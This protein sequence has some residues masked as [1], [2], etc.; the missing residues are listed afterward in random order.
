MNQPTLQMKTIPEDATLFA[1]FELG[2]DKWR[3]AF[4]NA[5]GEQKHA[6]IPAKDTELL[7]VARMRNYFGLPADALLV[8]CYEC[9]C[10]ICRRWWRSRA[11]E[12]TPSSP[13]RWTCSGPSRWIPVSAR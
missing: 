13:F 3:I 9:S 2:A 1:S 4:G 6:V 7:A 11:V 12:T 8:T 5:A 10:A